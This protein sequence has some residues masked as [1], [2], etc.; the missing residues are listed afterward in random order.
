[1]RTRACVNP[2]LAHR[3]SWVQLDSN[4]DGTEEKLY[5]IRVRFILRHVESFND[6]DLLL[7]EFLSPVIPS[8]WKSE[9]S[10]C[11]SAL[12]LDHKPTN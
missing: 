12:Q 5:H 4:G 1:M 6:R 10:G 3:R 9:V 11:L 7:V 2:V 8:I